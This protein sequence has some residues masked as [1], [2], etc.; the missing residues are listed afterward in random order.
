MVSM[1]VEQ[2]KW[3]LSTLPG[4]CRNFNTKYLWRTLGSASK[5]HCICKTLWCVWISFLVCLHRKFT[6]CN[7]VQRN[8]S[9]MISVKYF[10]LLNQS[11]NLTFL[12]VLDLCFYHFLIKTQPYFQS[13]SLQTDQPFKSSG[14]L[15]YRSWLEISYWIL[16]L[17]D[18]RETWAVH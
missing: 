8:L 2:Y 9:S 18:L 5:E 1:A 15:R 6:F 11:F 16:N 4:Q 12:T 7:Y 13:G 3:C 10:S 14:K 17:I